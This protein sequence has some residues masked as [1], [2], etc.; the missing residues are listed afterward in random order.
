LYLAVDLNTLPHG[1]RPDRPSLDRTTSLE[2]IEMLLERGANP[3]ARLKLFPPYRALGPD[4]G[5]DMMLTIDATPLLRA[6]KAGDVPA[7]RL[8]LEY[9]ANPHL[10]NIYG[11]TPIMAA[12]GLGSNEID[13]RGKFKTQAQAVEAI[14][15]LVAA[16]ADV[17]AREFRRG[18]TALHGA[19]L[20]GWN[21]VVRALVAHHADL[22]AKDNN[23]MTPLDSAL[24]RA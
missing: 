24:G 16:G 14:E 19:A 15:L 22:Q 13:T 10:A 5:A 9:G 12:A 8:L 6:A 23:G 21:D 2:L 4:R 17:N 3:N 18:Q 11:H 1:G 7:I 20:W